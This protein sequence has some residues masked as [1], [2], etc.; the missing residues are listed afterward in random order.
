MLL[1]NIELRVETDAKTPQTLWC[2]NQALRCRTRSI[3]LIH[4]TQV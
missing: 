4:V 2:L 1:M 3:Y